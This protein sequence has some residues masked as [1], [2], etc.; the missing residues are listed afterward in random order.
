MNKSTLIKQLKTFT[1][2]EMREFHEYILSPY[3]NKNEGVIKLFDFIRKQFP[4]FEEK[5]LEKNY[6]YSRIFPNAEYNDGLMRTIMFNLS[7]L[8]DDYLAHIQFKQNFFLEKWC[9]LYELNERMLDKQID[10]NYKELGDKF[11]E[12]KISDSDYF[13]YK[14]LIENEYFYYMNRLNLDKAER[15]IADSGIEDMFNH[16]TYFY[17]LRSFKLF[18]YSLNAKDIYNI[19]FK[20]ALFEEIFK[21]LDPNDYKEV[22]AIELYYY[23]SMLHI[24]KEDTSIYFKLR[25]L[26]VETENTLNKYVLATTYVNLENYCKIKI[27]EGDNKFVEELFDILKM[28]LD[29]KLYCAHGYMS[30]KFYRCVVDTA[31]KLK[32]FEW[33]FK[34]IYDHKNN[35]SPADAE[36]TYNYSL[37]LY[38]FTSANLNKSLEHLSKVK[39]DEVYQKAEVRCLTSL[40]YYELGMIEQLYS[41]IDSFRHFLKNDDHI[42][43]ER[44]ILFSNFVNYIKILADIRFDEKKQEPAYIQKQINETKNI[45]NREWF[46]EKIKELV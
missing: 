45:F 30:A 41:Q 8:A 42:P 27:R 3:F 35:L 7:G 19:N 15:F 17:L 39:Y 32:E 36:N 9:L 16:L 18:E 25:E 24:N 13:M 12:I 43:R 6:V 10:K 1:A 31:L 22:P 26:L 20:T 44:K 46:V 23:M 33:T 37:A 29:K 11:K 14:F 38:E 28:E 5:K 2:K 34:F 21:N 4:R 40:L